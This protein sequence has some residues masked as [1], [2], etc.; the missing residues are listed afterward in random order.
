MSKQLFITLVASVVIVTTLLLVWKANNREVLDAFENINEKLEQSNRES[1]VRL[2]Y[3]YQTGFA[4]FEESADRLNSFLEELKDQIRDRLIDHDLESANGESITDYILLDGEVP[5]QR[6]LELVAEI[7]AFRATFHEDFN[8]LYP[9]LVEECNERFSTTP[10]IDRDGSEVD[11]LVYNFD[12]FPSVAVLT[13]L[14][15]FQSD[16]NYLRDELL[17]LEEE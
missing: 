5:S 16:I 7:S 1:N 10:A 6:G 12:G 17:L 3:G 4:S 11:W 9:G 8:E 15:Q 13:K 2:Y 14:S